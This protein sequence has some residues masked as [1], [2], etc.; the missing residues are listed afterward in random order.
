L[1]AALIRAV[2][3]FFFASAY[4]A[5]LPLVARNQIAGG[6]ELYGTLLGAIGIG[7]VVGA[8]MLPSMK[9]ALGSDRLVAAGTLG[10]A[11][12]LVL[13]GIARHSAIGIAA[14]AVAGVS[15]IAVLASLNVSVQMSLPDWVRG[16][17]LAM[18]VTVFFGAMTA[19][20]A[21]WGQL[22]LGA[23]LAGGALHRRRRRSCRNRGDL[24]LEA[25]VRCGSRSRTLD[26]L[27]GAGL[28]DRRRWRSRSGI[29]NG[30]VPRRR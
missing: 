16:R 12:S 20:S 7:A 18:F 5:L 4:W 23:R 2:A 3:F 25:P 6:P 10:T 22:C 29:G 13:L 30:R 28:G 11:L 24:A 14:C 15:W 17:G 26:A 21:L 8:F 1:R 9:A 19:G 27:A